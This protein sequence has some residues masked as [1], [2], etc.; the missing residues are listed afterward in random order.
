MAYLQV[1]I[2]AITDVEVGGIGKWELRVFFPSLTYP[3]LDR[4]WSQANSSMSTILASTSASVHVWL[5]GSVKPGFC[6]L[7]LVYFHS[8]VPSPHIC[9]L[10]AFHLSTPLFRVACGGGG[11]H[12]TSCCVGAGIRPPRAALW[13]GPPAWWAGPPAR[14]V[15][16]RGAGQEKRRRQGAMR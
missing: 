3:S 15:V 14:G 8:W 2:K 6:L 12:F 13:H 16:E 10:W 4:I 11:R 5:H 9:K 7:C 1:C